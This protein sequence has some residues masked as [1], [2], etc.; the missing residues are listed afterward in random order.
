MHG[1]EHACDKLVDAEAFFHKR[2][3]SRDSA[4]VIG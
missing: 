4:F 3:Q 2:H 1:A